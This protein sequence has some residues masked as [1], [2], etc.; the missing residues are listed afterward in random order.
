M[1]ITFLKVHLNLAPLYSSENLD[2]EA[3]CCRI[4][5]KTDGLLLV[6]IKYKSISRLGQRRLAEAKKDIWRHLSFCLG[7]FLWHLSL[8]CCIIIVFL[9]MVQW[10]MKTI[11]LSVLVNIA[12]FHIDYFYFVTNTHLCG[13][14]THLSRSLLCP[15]ITL[16]LNIPSHQLVIVF[17]LKIT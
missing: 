7:S 16:I 15:A 9:Q 13:K 1:K 5:E 11:I 8:S 14:V 2:L 12:V 10:H 3:G 17:M 6:D 4:Q